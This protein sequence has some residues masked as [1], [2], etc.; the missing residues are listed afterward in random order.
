IQKYQT[1]LNIVKTQKEYDAIRS[2]VA[3]C[4]KQISDF[5]TSALEA[6]EKAE[7]LT[8][9]ARGMDPAIATRKKELEAAR[10]VLADQ[11]ADLA[12]R[13]EKAERSRAEAVKPIDPEELRRY[14]NAQGKYPGAAMSR[15]DNGICVACNMKLSPQVYNL[16]LIGD[17]PQQ[18]RSCGRVLYAEKSAG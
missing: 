7:T 1:Q 2:E 3:G 10:S 12:H 14:D 17:P 4:Q 15:V 18:C 11:L 16:V 9:R 5:E 13:R 8:G 6:Y